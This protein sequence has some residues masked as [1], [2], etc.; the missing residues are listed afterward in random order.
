MNT[1]ASVIGDT[2][3]WVVAIFVILFIL[4]IYLF[5]MSVMG[6]KKAY[7][8]TN[9]IKISEG[10]PE[11]LAYIEGFNAFLNTKIE[12]EGKNEIVLDAIL[13]R[14]DVYFVT[15]SKYPAVGTM[16]NRYGLNKVDD[17]GAVGRDRMMKE[18]FDIKTLIKID[19]S[20]QVLGEAIRKELDQHCDRYLLLIP[21]GLINE[22]GLLASSSILGHEVFLNTKDRLKVWTPSMN[23]KLRYRGQNIEIKYRQRNDC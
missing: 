16:I 21:Q 19:Q 7:F 13:N 20:N 15:Q 14:L 4:V 9:E 11:H 23:Y 5:F 8:E 22:N 18:G 12:V 3:T 10:N 17:I 2:F 1:K 6:A